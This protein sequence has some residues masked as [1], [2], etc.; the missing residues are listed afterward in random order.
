MGLQFGNML[1]V[2]LTFVAVLAKD[3]FN[4]KIWGSRLGGVAFPLVAIEAPWE[5]AKATI[6]ACAIH[7]SG[8]IP[9]EFCLDCLV[10]CP[11]ILPSASL[12]VGV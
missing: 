5:R 2:N 12:S 4:W 6:S 3:I 7:H 8:T 11:H 1:A 9:R 10:L